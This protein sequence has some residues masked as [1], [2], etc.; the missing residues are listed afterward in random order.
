MV[1]EALNDNGLLDQ[2]Y[3]EDIWYNI[4][5]TSYIYTAFAAAE[6]AVK[7]GGFSTK[8]YYNDYSI[9]NPGNKSTAAQNIVAELNARGIQ[10]DGVGLQSHFIVGETPTT[11][12]QMENMNAFVALDVDVAVTELDV[13][14]T[15]PATLEAQQQQVLDYASTIAACA[16][17]E[18]C[19][20]VTL[21]DFDD[22]YSWIPST[23]AGQGYGDVWFQPNG[24]D[25]P[26]VTKA[27]Y[28][29]IV[30]GWTGVVPTLGDT[31]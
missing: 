8:L 19:V 27:A 23:F 11:A 25:T 15:T 24:S 29:G 14:T 1:N 9:E 10:I 3:R 22:T 31:K 16:G 13:R 12:Q 30:D 5:G 17:V 2:P 4:T 6:A 18:R 26:L 28:D 21:W 20:G 7:A